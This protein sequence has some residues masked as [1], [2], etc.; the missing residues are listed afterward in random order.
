MDI[1]GL[2]TFAMIHEIS[3][4]PKHVSVNSCKWVNVA[5]TLSDEI[6]NECFDKQ[7][8]IQEAGLEAYTTDLGWTRRQNCFVCHQV[9]SQKQ[10]AAP[11]KETLRIT[12]ML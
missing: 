7:L 3:E 6:T 1:V 4:T 9:L 12:A 2:S 10:R 5:K 8:Q 11:C